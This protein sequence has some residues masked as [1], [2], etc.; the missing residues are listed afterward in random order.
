MYLDGLTISIIIMLETSITL[1][2]MRMDTEQQLVSEPRTMFTLATASIT[3]L[4]TGSMPACFPYDRSFLNFVSGAKNQLSCIFNGVFC[5]ALGFV[6]FE[7][8]AYLPQLA[9]EAI[10]MA[11]SLRTTRVGEII[12]TF[13]HDRKLFITN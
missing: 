6:L 10:L 5:V 3:S 4:V 7:L 1:S 9:L 13:K 11:L 12:Y 2:M 8:F